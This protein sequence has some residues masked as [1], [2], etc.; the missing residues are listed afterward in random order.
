MSSLKQGSQTRNVRARHRCAR[1]YIELAAPRILW[2]FRRRHGVR[3]GGQD[4]NTRRDHVG[5]QNV[6]RRTIRPPRREQR[7]YGRGLHPQPCP[8]RNYYGPRVLRTAD[9]IANFVAR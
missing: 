3:P 4:V 5:L 2:E 7:N 1:E 8:V 9:V 6:R